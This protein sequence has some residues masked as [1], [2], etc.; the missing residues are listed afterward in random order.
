MSGC[1]EGDK[2][3]QILLSTYNG[4]KYLR[5]QL[6]SYLA[7]KNYGEVKV[8]IRDDGSTDGTPDILRKYEKAEG[9]KVL[10][11]SNVGINAS[12]TEL[13]QR[14]DPNCE[15]FSF[16]DQDDVWLPDKLSTAVKAIASCPN[17]KI[18]ILCASRSQVTDEA[19]EPIGASILP[20][21]GLS[22]Y[23]AMVQ[24]VCP[25]HTQVFNRKL[26]DQLLQGDISHAHVL[27]WWVYLVAS[28][29][30]RVVFLEEHTVLH[31]QHKGNAVGYQ[32]D[33][34][35]LFFTRL[36]RVRSD[37]AA[38][39]TCQLEGF[40]SD[41]GEILPEVC[42]LEVERFLNSQDHF[43]ERVRYAF[44]G[45]CFRQTRYET[46]LVRCLYAVGK[47]RIRS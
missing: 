7:Q 30:G 37:E 31:R 46:L 36:K 3:I 27:D 40:L 18:P 5:E 12:Y 4:E 20:V 1:T 44:G 19:L 17:Q 10:Y 16:S 2:R 42:R 38:Q 9:F 39:I 26:R 34:L 11:G 29:L 25:G 24:N 21:R 28:G 33:I 22:F 32:L 43:H 13:L 8:L 15:Y 14:S 6:D 41:Y 35:R 23:N 47:Y 45:K